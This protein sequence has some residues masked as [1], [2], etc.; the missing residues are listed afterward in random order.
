MALTLAA[1]GSG[2]G[3]TDAAA[4]SDKLGATVGIAM[5]TKVSTPGSPTATR[6]AQQFQALGYKTDLQYPT[7]T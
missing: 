1:C 5:P 2:G 7:T 4:K 3:A 6:L